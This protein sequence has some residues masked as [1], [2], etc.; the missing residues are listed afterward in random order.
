MPNSKTIER[1]ISVTFSRSLEAPLV[2]R[3]K[4]TCSAARPPSATFITSRNSS[5]VCR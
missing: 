3:P 2:T 1:A 4:T 5:F